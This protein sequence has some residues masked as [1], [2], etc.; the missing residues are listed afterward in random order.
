MHNLKN[1]NNNNWHL[2]IH[3]YNIYRLGWLGGS[4]VYT[5]WTVYGLHVVHLKN[6]KHGLQMNF[7]ATS[8]AICSPPNSNILEKPLLSIL[9]A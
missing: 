5:L 2:G 8:S 7:K 6:V 1:N 4:W 3:T 9:K